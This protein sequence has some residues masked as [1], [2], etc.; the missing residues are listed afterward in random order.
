MQL[1]HINQSSLLPLSPKRCL[2]NSDDLIHSSPVED[3]RPHSLVFNH[4]HVDGGLRTES[5]VTSGC[6]SGSTGFSWLLTLRPAQWSVMI[7][8]CDIPTRFKKSINETWGNR[9]EYSRQTVSKNRAAFHLSA[10][11]GSELKQW[12][13]DT[14]V[15]PRIFC[16]HKRGRQIKVDHS[17]V[18]SM[19][20][21][22]VDVGGVTDAKTKFYLSNCPTICVPKTVRRTIGS[23][24]DHKQYISFATKPQHFITTTDLLPCNNLDTLIEI[25]TWFSPTGTSY[26]T[27]KP[28]EITCIKLQMIPL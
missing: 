11:D 17:K 19:L 8:M 25:P 24:L 28:R 22:H 1:T 4:G 7:V 9:L 16:L 20:I 18:Q 23:V 3:G 13:L 12:L 10:G 2:V 5:I 26:R 21:H 14:A 6:V 27:L 15:K